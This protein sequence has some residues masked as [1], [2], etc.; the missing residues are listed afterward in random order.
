MSASA[1][2]IPRHRLSA[3]DFDGAVQVGARRQAWHVLDGVHDGGAQAKSRDRYR[4]WGI[5]IEG[6]LAECAFARAFRREWSP[7]EGMHDTNLGDVAGF[8]IRGTGFVR[9]PDLKVYRKDPNGDRYVL[10]VGGG[11]DWR[12][13]GWLWGTDA[14]QDRYWREP[15]DGGPY[16]IAVPC[17]CVPAD[18][19]RPM[20]DFPF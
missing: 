11:R 9:A 15:N 13:P 17:F 7:V 16:P 3:I 1:A 20:E 19:L 14:K 5:A 6:A 12:F 18:A 8:Q 4:A 2:T 10:A